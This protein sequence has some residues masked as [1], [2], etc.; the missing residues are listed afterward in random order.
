MITTLTAMPESRLRWWKLLIIGSALALAAGCSTLRV[1]YSSGPTLAWWQ[2]DGWVDADR[3]Q[4]PAVRAAIERWFAWHRGTQFG[5]TAALLADARGQVM[6]PTD[7]EAVCRFNQRAQALLQP[8]IARA[9]EEAADLVPLLTEANF[10]AMEAKGAEELEEDREQFLNPDPAERRAAALDRTRQRYERLY[11]RLT[12][13]QLAVLREGL[14]DLPL[15]PER[16]LAEREQRQRETVA[17]LRRLQAERAP[18]EQRLAALRALVD[19]AWAAPD[20]ERRARQ[21]RLAEAN[22]ALAARLHNATTVAQRERARA[23]LQGWEDDLRAVMR[24]PAG[25]ATAAPST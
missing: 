17:T 24:P 5:P 25:S 6:Q 3:D 15:N 2:L 19:T 22:C 18:R 12:E 14:P 16:W 8:A 21:Q 11:G 10:K 1:A 13:R 23:N 20:P 7:G 4:A 9:L